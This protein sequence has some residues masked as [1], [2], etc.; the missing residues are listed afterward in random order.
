MAYTTG[1]LALMTDAERRLLHA[2][3]LMARQYLMDPS[4]RGEGMLDSLSM[5]AGENAIE[6]LTHYGLVSMEPG[7]ARFGKWTQAGYDFLDSN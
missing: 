5:S 7:Q 4:F 2:L 3:A 6:L 1:R